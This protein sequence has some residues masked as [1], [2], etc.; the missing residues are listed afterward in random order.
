MDSWKK[1]VL[2]TACV[3]SC[4]SNVGSALPS[5]IIQK[6]DIFLN[7]SHPFAEF[8]LNRHAH[9]GEKRDNVP[10]RILSL[11]ASIMS[12]TGSST[13]NGY[14]AHIIPGVSAV[15]DSDNS[16]VFESLLEMH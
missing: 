13:G 1:I 8:G 11:G 6:D 2:A 7:S 4:L 3:V 16:I 14:V 5:S 12:G 15:F 10:L 9:A